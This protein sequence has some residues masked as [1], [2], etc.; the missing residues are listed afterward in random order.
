MNCQLG[1]GWASWFSAPNWS[2]FLYGVLVRGLWLWWAAEPNATYGR[3]GFSGLV[4][5]VCH[6]GESR[7]ALKA[8]VWRQRLGK[9][10]ALNLSLHVLFCTL[11]YR[12]EDHLPRG[13]I[14]HCGLDPPTSI[15]IKTMS[16][17]PACS[18]TETF[19][20]LRFFLPK[21]DPSLCQVGKTK[22]NK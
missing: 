4:V 11:S 16:H 13:G 15:V 9:S 22:T 6:D 17:K 7:Q 8:G 12:T 3:K 19:S 20:Y 1:L 2:H 10:A 18:L 5:A 21:C 14:T